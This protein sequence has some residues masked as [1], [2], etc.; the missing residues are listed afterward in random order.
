MSQG[1][2]M[3]TSAPTVSVLMTAYNRADFIADAMGSVLASDFG[4]FE[5]IVVDDGSSDRTVEIA[6]ELETTDSRVRVCQNEKN[7]GDYPNR[8]H[9]ASLARGKY[10]KYVDS[11]DMIYPWGLG[12]FV[13]CMEQFPEAGF[14]LSAHSAP[15]RPH[16]MI[17][18]PAEAYREEFHG[19]ELFGR[20]PGSGIVRR[21]AYEAVG[22]FSGMR[23]LG[24][25]EFWLK[26]GARYPVVTLPPALV[27]DRVHGGQ[28]KNADSD[29]EKTAMRAGVVI[30]ALES[31]DCPL[32]GPQRQAALV[33]WRQK[34]MRQFWR[35][36][37]RNRRPAEALRYYQ[38]INASLK[39]A[40]RADG[41]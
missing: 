20:A 3:T 11:D 13:R 27:W 22:G 31:P 2:G 23:Q 16:P 36:L 18:S 10:L 17:F 7:L 5:L 14:G 12:V 33:S 24:D 9:A 41:V 8:K 6:R 4:D 32:D 21:D 40:G 19:R 15:D 25:M 30:A 28:E 1:N 34:H 26:I 35:H 37:L 39:G 29:T 38:A